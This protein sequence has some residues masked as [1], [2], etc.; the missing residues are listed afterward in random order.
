LEERA[1]S[2]AREA[3]LLGP[4]MYRYNRDGARAG[5]T[6]LES[7]DLYRLLD[8][9]AT[10]GAR[11]CAMEVS[12]H[13]LSLDR[14]AGVAFKAAVFTNLTQDHLDFHG[15]M[16]AYFDAKAALFRD[17]PASSVA[18]LNADDPCAARLRSAPRARVVTFGA[19]A[20]A[21]VRLESVETDVS[22]TRLVLA[23]PGGAL[24]VRSPLLGRPNALNMA[25]AAA[26]ALA[27]DVGP[28]RI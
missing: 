1:G 4:V 6:T 19:A 15:T 14:V 21:D 13:S 22:G 10:A 17:L 23:A 7:L 20:Q 12:S 26:T 28:D 25:A 9:Y 5:R 2:T 8:R 18:I 16:E 24:R 27:L 11:S 3:C